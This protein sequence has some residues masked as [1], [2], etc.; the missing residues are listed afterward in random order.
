VTKG[1]E[2]IAESIHLVLGLTD[3]YPR[4]S[5]AAHILLD[6]VEQFLPALFTRRM[7]VHSPWQS[8][9][10]SSQCQTLPAW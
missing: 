10:D 9:T 8:T 3:R 7:H 2:D 1:G 6:V 5:I 4:A